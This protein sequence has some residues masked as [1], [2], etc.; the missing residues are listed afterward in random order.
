MLFRSDEGLG[1]VNYCQ[2]HFGRPERDWINEETL[3]GATIDSMPFF[4]QKYYSN[5][6]LDN[7]GHLE[8][9]LNCQDIKFN[10]LHFLSFVLGKLGA[11]SHAKYLYPLMIKNFDFLRGM[12]GIEL[13]GTT[14]PSFNLSLEEFRDCLRNGFG[15]KKKKSKLFI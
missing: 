6:G 2:R 8:F 10:N 12:E 5:I 4:K 3:I 1:Y 13:F 14:N 9:F 7:H 11:Q 15:A